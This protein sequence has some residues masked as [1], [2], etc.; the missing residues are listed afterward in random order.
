MWWILTFTILVM[1]FVAYLLHVGEKA[2]AR[3]MEI[4]AAS[5]CDCLLPREF[6]ENTGDAD[7]VELPLTQP[8]PEKT[9]RKAQPGLLSQT[10]G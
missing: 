3:E 1:L 6:S 2:Q 9:G 5:K 7:T 8:V 10:G 4:K